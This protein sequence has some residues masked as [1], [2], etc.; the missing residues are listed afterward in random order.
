[1]AYW[2]KIIIACLF[3]LF[4]QANTEFIIN[5]YWF[6]G[7]SGTYGTNSQA[8]NA[9][10]NNVPSGYLAQITI[11]C[12]DSSFNIC[13]QLDDYNTS[14]REVILVL[15]DDDGGSNEPSTLLESVTVD[16]TSES[17]QAQ[18]EAI[19]Y[20]ISSGI[21]WIGAIFESTTTKYGYLDT[22]TGTGRYI[23]NLGSFAAPDPWPHATDSTSTYNRSFW[24]DFD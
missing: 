18:C 16:D 6:A 9:G 20:S 12:N 24:L 10:A 4:L 14:D 3:V 7:C 23:Q 11:D 15:Y 22:T 13:G 19:T 21:Y 5:S 1:M 17:L 8:Y 2:R